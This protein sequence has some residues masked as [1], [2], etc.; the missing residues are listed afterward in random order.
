[1]TVPS[2]PIVFVGIDWATQ[3]HEVCV[4]D[5]S[6]RVLGQKAFLNNA[7]GLE[8]LVHWLIELAG[9]VVEAIAVAIERPDGLVVEA[10]LDYGIAVYTLNPMQLD[11]F[12]DRFS[13][14]GAKDDRRDG[15]VLADSLRTDGRAFHLVVPPPSE[16]VVL[17]GSAREDDA[18]RIEESV[19]N[20][21][22]RDLLARYYPQML[23]LAA[24]RVAPVLWDLW[25]SGSHVGSR[26]QREPTGHRDPTAPASYPATHCR[27]GDEGS[28][29]PSTASVR[30]NDRI[31]G[32]GHWPVAASLAAGT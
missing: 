7:E 27:K 18:L 22:L 1:M 11:R 25:E 17:R 24:D 31:L 12:R 23:A 2:S 30:R 9:G 28:H 10:L 3:A 13:V 8:A 32:P 15:L 26:G 21:R 16:V 5:G 20:N 19:L 14:A 29:R 6:G 4:L